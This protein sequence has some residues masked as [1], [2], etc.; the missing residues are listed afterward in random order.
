MYLYYDHPQ[1]CLHITIQYMFTC[2]CTSIHSSNHPCFIQVCSAKMA[3]FRRKFSDAARRYIQLSYEP[4]IHP[5]ERMTSL[6]RAMICTILSS[7][8]VWCVSLSVCL[9]VCLSICLSVCLFVYLSVTIHVY[10]C[11][12][13]C[14]IVCF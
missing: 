10:P 14:D 9:S 2:T 3:D 8:G 13:V 12:C 6:K 1:Q 4:A 5:D 11:V 7:A